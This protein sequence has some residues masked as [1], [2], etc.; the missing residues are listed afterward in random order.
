MDDETSS[1][2]SGEG[3]EV[4]ME[5]KLETITVVPHLV[6]K[7]LW[8]ENK[9]LNACVDGMGKSCRL[10]EASEVKLRAEIERLQGIVN[11][12]PKTKDA[13]TATPLMRVYFPPGYSEHDHDGIVHVCVCSEGGDLSVTDAYSTREAR[14]AAE[15]A[16]GKK[17]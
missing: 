9:R 2:P 5:G 7:N 16:E 12:Y 4:M 15:A 17:C 1:R 11:K 13:V 6:G 8:Y 10:F 3:E 14:A